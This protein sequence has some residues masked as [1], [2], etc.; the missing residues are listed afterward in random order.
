MS[1]SKQNQD[2]HCGGWEGAERETL[3]HMAGLSF[4]GKLRWL[5][6][7]QEIIVAFHGEEAANL[8]SGSIVPPKT[9]S[10]C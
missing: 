3:R 4:E 8:P 9:K 6:E 2:W 1:E 7:A 10:G 5:E